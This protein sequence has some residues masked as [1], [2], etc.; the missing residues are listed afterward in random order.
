MQN[1]PK[2]MNENDVYQVLR[3]TALGLAAAEEMNIIH[4]DIKPENLMY[5]AAGEIKI[6]DLGLR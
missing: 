3:E 5:G 2:G 1:F 6:A 4:R